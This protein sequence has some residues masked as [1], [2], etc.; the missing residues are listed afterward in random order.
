[1]SETSDTIPAP[2]S[3]SVENAKPIDPLERAIVSVDYLSGRVQA[4]EVALGELTR[5]VKRPA[6]LDELLERIAVITPAATT[7]A[8][9]VYLRE[10]VAE[11]EERCNARH[12]RD[13]APV[14]LRSNGSGG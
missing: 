14:P 12:E 3:T 8:E 5:Q 9:V 13:P 7:S 6:W 4:V 11:L 2:P 10:R 1:M